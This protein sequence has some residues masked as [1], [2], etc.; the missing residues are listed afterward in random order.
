MPIFHKKIIYFFFIV[1]TLTTNS[2]IKKINY[3]DGKLFGEGKMIDGKKEGEWVYY[4]KTGEILA[5]G[6]FKEGKENGYWEGYVPKGDIYFKGNYI[7]GNKVGTWLQGN[8]VF[9]DY[10]IEKK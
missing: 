5:K 6:P 2:Q 9:L 4:H 1:F 8:S 10:Y 7:N 3:N